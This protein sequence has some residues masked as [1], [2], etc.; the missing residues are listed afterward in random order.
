MAIHNFGQQK[1][2]FISIDR[3]PD[4]RSEV[5][6]QFTPLSI[7]DHEKADIALAERWSEEIINVSGA[8]VSFY[9]YIPK[10][11]SE[12]EVWDTDPNPIYKRPVHMKAF[13]KPEE[14]RF[15]FTRWGIDIPIKATVVMSRAVMIKQVG[16]RLA[17]PGDIFELPYNVPSIETKL[18]DH[19]IGPKRFRVLNGFSSG[20]FM[21]RWL[22]ITALCQLITGDKALNVVHRG[23]GGV[24]Q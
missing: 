10:P 2:R 15:E 4:F 3:M 7:Y 20:M 6:K 19:H 9:E 21:Y 8:W 17:V 18:E 14:T 23:I 16:T 12:L 22:Y 24:N 5:E 11:D 13:F 1:E